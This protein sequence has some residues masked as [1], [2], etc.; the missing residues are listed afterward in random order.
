MYQITIDSQAVSRPMEKE[1]ADIWEG[2][3]RITFPG[4]TILAIPLLCESCGN[5]LPETGPCWHNLFPEEE[6][7]PRPTLAEMM[8]TEAE[9]TRRMEIRLFGRPI[10]NKAG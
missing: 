6:L 10:Q 9:L 7:E 2:L 1:E 3:L 5:P 4:T 8:A